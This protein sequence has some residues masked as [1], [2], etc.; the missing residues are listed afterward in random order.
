MQTKLDFYIAYL[1]EGNE[2]KESWLKT[3]GIKKMN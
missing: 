2:K 1:K 3:V